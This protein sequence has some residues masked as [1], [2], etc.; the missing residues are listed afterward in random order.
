[1]MKEIISGFVR[2][3][4]VKVMLS[5]KVL[6]G[7]LD[8]F[9]YNWIGSD[10]KYYSLLVACNDTSF[11]IKTGNTFRLSTFDTATTLKDALRQFECKQDWMTGKWTLQEAL[12]FC[13]FIEQQLEHNYS[14]NVEVG[15]YKLIS[16]KFWIRPALGVSVFYR[17]GDFTNV[18]NFWYGSKTTIS[19][20][21][22][23]FL[24][25]INELGYSDLIDVVQVIGGD[26]NAI[27][28]VESCN[29]FEQ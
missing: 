3:L 21:D 19:T 25:F 7:T 8:T 26:L 1:M 10:G 14:R 15:C 2:K 28:A 9:Y 16:E 27:T 22:S 17:V 13:S 6:A 24:D 20:N 18:L 5:Q 11:F 12:T 29:A 23:D 4:G